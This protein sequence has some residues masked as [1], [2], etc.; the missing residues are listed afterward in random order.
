MDEKFVI[1][2]DYSAMGDVTTEPWLF[3]TEPWLFLLES[4]NC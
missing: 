2:Y 1:L 4:L 3:L